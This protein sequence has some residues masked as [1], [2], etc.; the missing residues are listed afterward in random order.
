M[1][2]P[3]NI[4]KEAFELKSKKALNSELKKELKKLETLSIEEIRV[5]TNCEY[6]EIYAA[7]SE[8]ILDDLCEYSSLTDIIL[9]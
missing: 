7:V 6:S 5:A 3:L 8:L 9:V 4:I 2:I 1:E